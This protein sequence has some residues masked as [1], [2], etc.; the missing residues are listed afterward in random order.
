LA[1]WKAQQKVE[2]AVF[3]PRQAERNDKSLQNFEVLKREDKKSG[4]DSYEYEEVEVQSKRSQK[5]KVLD[6]DVN[7]SNT[8]RAT[9]RREERRPAPQSSRAGNTRQSGPS[10]GNAPSS[11]VPRRQQRLNLNTQE[12]PALS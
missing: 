9:N 5:N 4:D 8:S 6:I 12:F 7:F 3:N 11:S 10:S 1:E 2:K